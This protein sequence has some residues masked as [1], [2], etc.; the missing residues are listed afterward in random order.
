[1]V[2]RCLPVCKVRSL[3]QGLRQGPRSGLSSTPLPS[4]IPGP[5]A[6]NQPIRFLEEPS[7]SPAF[8]SILSFSPGAH[9]SSLPPTRPIAGGGQV[10][11]YTHIPWALPLELDWPG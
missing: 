5:G 7:K 10:D 9:T 1:M 3:L 6:S 2:E 11:L 8:Y 4:P